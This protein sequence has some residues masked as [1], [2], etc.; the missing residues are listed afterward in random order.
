LLRGC[1]RGINQNRIPELGSNIA[2]LSVLQYID[3]QPYLAVTSVTG[4]P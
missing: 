1:G 3:N 2:R 4:L